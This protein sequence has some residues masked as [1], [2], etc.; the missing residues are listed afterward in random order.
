MYV[1]HVCVYNAFSYNVQALLC[2]QTTKSDI[3]CTDSSRIKQ[4]V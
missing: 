1:H 3:S 2:S 4:I